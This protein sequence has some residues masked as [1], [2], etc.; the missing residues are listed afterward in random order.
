[1]LGLKVPPAPIVVV[2]LVVAVAVVDFGSLSERPI[3][4]PQDPKFFKLGILN[5][6]IFFQKGLCIKA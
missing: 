4:M 1:M 3:G 2:G 5:F 6:W